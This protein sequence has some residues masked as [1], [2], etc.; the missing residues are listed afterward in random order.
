M[1]AIKGA[2]GPVLLRFLVAAAVLLGVGLAI[3]AALGSTVVP[4]ASSH[5]PDPYLV[6]PGTPRPT[7]TATASAQDQKKRSAPP[8]PGAAGRPIA[9]PQ[10]GSGTFVA[11]A[12]SGPVHGG[13]GRLHRY[14]VEVEGGTG[15]DPIEVAAIV[16][17]VLGDPRSWIGGGNV[18]LQLV[19]AGAPADF[20]VLLAS[21][22]TTEAICASGGLKTN[23]YASCRLPG[24]VVL[25]LAR[26]LTAVPDYGAS[27]EEY[28]RYLVNHEVGHQLGHGHEACPGPGQPAPVMQQQTYGLHGCVANAWPYIGGKRYAGRPVK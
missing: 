16:D 26:W 15:S 2:I 1:G 20:S 3:G 22:A 11:A 5:R 18:R 25:N 13:A 14:R 27:L 4:D 9:V 10:T 7:A 6:Q 19:P 28:R 23:G 12:A 8:A 21:P 24:R 17:A